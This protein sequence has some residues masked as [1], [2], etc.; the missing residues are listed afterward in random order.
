MPAR[1]T[2]TAQ[3][4]SL[5]N[6]SKAVTD[7]NRRKLLAAEAN[8]RADRER[9]GAKQALEEDADRKRIEDPTGR[10][11]Y[12]AA[13][14]TPGYAVAYGFLGTG[15]GGPGTVYVLKAG[16]GT[17]SDQFTGPS[18]PPFVPIP[19]PPGAFT[20]YSYKLDSLSTAFSFTVLLPV[21]SSSFIFY[22]TLTVTRFEAT[23]FV[24][25]GAVSSITT[26]RI[27][28]SSAGCFLISKE[29][30]RAIGIPGPLASLSFHDPGQYNLQLTNQW[31][32]EPP[33]TRPPLGG[34]IRFPYRLRIGPGLPPNENP[35]NSYIQDPAIFK[36][37]KNQQDFIDNGGDTEYASFLESESPPRIALSQCQLNGTCSSSQWGFDLTTNPDEPEPR[38]RKNIKARRQVG[39]E[40]LLQDEPLITWD[41]GKPGYC[42]EQLLS[43]GFSLGD[44][45]P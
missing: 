18:L 36:I 2:V 12:L 17:T 38:Y 34:S 37:I 25:N 22:R 31:L 5:L 42:K 19:P 33:E 15:P 10:N 21:D 35:D 29:S 23:S 43:L 14:G 11:I 30:V 4:E 7:A 45:T 9:L 6:Q 1:I 26:E 27:T 44:L 32:G 24:T 13:G 16:D 20:D 8:R 41:W 28:S 40:D 3:L 39:G